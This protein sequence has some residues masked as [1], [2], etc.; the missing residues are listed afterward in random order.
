[1]KNILFI[2]ESLDHFLLKQALL[3]LNNEWYFC[4]ILIW[5]EKQKNK[6]KYIEWLYKECF[7]FDFTRI[8]DTFEFVKNLWI[9]FDWVLSLS[10]EIVTPIVALIWNHFWCKWNSPHT[11]FLCRSKYHMR[12][13]LSEN[14]VPQPKFKLCKN[15]NELKQA[16]IDIKVPCVAKPIWAHSSYWTFLIINE[17]DLEL[18]EENYK[19]SIK[20]LDDMANN[21]DIE[22][23][24]LSIL[25]KNGLSLF[26]IND[27]INMI[28]DYLV[29]EFMPWKEISVDSI[30][31]DWITTILWIA[32]QVRM[33]P[34]FFVQ[35]AEKMPLVCDNK[36]K[37]EIISVVNQTIKAVWIEN[38]LSH[39]ELMLT[40]NWVKVVEIA[41][42]MWWDN[43]PDFVFQTTWYNQI[44]ENAYLSLW[45]SR[46]YDTS[47]PK[48]YMAM[49]YILPKKAWII[50]EIKVPE[51]LKN[52][53]WIITQIDFIYK[54]WEKVAPPPE[55]FDYIWFVS[56]KGQTP[57]E[58]DKNLKNALD[59]IEIIIE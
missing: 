26:W 14:S 29:E 45:I 2:A 31:K 50:K 33:D 55:W 3:N 34:P 59:K 15:F 6:L 8:I 49:E 48:S 28:T 53:R 32:D 22:A 30:T 10:C 42:R 47:I 17:K 44:L 41:C 23:K 27:D 13:I 19:K 4:Y 5:N 35:L 11:S 40:P 24:D 37:E 7:V 16:I 25:D 54:V 9:N 12:K 58:A 46:N 56:A 43:I 20:Y 51:E 38:S 36:L 57:E 18:I 52:N 1:M 39:I 21:Q